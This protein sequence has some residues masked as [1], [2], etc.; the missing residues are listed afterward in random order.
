MFYDLL[1][2]NVDKRSALSP[3]DPQRASYDRTIATIQANIS[4]L[5]ASYPDNPDALDIAL[6]WVKIEQEEHYSVLNGIFS[7]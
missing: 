5:R 2:S 3:D 1:E 7:E 6:E 4:Q